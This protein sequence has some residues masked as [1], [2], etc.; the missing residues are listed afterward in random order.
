MEKDP[1]LHLIDGKI[2]VAI[3]FHFFVQKRIINMRSRV[4]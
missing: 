3:A 4:T 1:K 2:P